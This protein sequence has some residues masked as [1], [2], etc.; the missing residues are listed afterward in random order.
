M[1]SE[2]QFMQRFDVYSATMKIPASPL[3]VLYNT[4]RLT[5]DHPS[6]LIVATNRLQQQ[7]YKPVQ[8]PYRFKPEDIHKLDFGD[9]D[10]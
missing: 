4:L 1:E 3:I 8:Q 6:A 5:Y 7:E 9:V 2:A 10:E